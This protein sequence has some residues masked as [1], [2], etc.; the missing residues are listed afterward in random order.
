MDKCFSNFKEILSGDFWNALLGND[1]NKGYVAALCFVLV[2]I[3]ILLLI[4]FVLFLVFRTRKCKSIVIPDSQG[5]VS[6]SRT[7][8]ENAV[9]KTVSAYPELNL[10]ALKLYRKGSSYALNLHCILD[11]SHGT[12]FSTLVENLRPALL[13]MLKDT[14]GITRLRKIRFILEEYEAA[15]EEIP[16]PETGE[17]QAA[18]EE[19][20]VPET[21][22]SQAANETD[23]GL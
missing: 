7:A 5:D 15:N 6:I 19:I 12:A 9:R 17:S 22:E 10:R 13:E 20:P 14:F 3:L 1:F 2:L 21:G 18:N 16:V 23:P 4:R 11:G 8:V